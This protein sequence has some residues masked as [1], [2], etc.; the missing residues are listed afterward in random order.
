MVQRTLEQLRLGGLA[1]LVGGSLTSCALTLDFDK[2]EGCQECAAADPCQDNA[3]TR[4]GCLPRPEDNPVCE[5]DEPTAEAGPARC[6][7]DAPLSPYLRFTPLEAEV[8]FQAETLTTPTR[9]YHAVYVGNADDT[10]DVIVRAFDPSGDVVE[11]T[12]RAPIATARLSELIATRLGREVTLVAPASMVQAAKGNT[13]VVYTAIAPQGTETADVIRVDIDAG[14]AK[15]SAVTFLT[16]IPNFQIDDSAGRGGPAAGTLANGEPFVVWQGCKPDASTPNITLET[17]LCKVAADSGTIYGHTGTQ[18]L[19]VDSL[20]AQGISED[21]FASSIQALSGAT[22]PGAVWAASSLTDEELHVRAGLP[23]PGS[24]LDLLQCDDSQASAQWLSATPIWGPVASI[25]WTKSSATAEATRVQCLDE[26][27]RDLAVASDAGDSASCSTTLVNTRVFL[28]VSYLA[29]G[30]WA[31]SNADETAWT[32][33]AYVQQDGSETR[34][35][36]TATQATPDPNQTRL[37]NPVP[38][39]ELPSSN[40]TKVVLS[41]QKYSLN[42]QRGLVSVGWVER[43]GSRQA[44]MLSALDLCVA[45]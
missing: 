6:S 25:G 45:Q 43:H 11:E 37:I 16:E 40:P 2:F 9:I 30:I 24:S 10:R 31:D 8:I 14:L 38:T 13:L 26:T 3:C 18:S 41:L 1:A 42:A 19:S 35:L 32:V 17:D 20:A 4:N 29:H 33:A 21:L 44:A 34:L 27:C 36:T 12:P 39:L 28:N 22:Y 23:E 7:G 5:Q 15:A